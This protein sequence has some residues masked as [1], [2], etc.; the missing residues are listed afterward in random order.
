MSS[1]EKTIEALLEVLAEP[2]IAYQKV[3]SL[4]TGSV[5]AGLLF[6]Q[7][8]YWWRREWPG[9]PK[10]TPFYKTDKDFVEFL[11]MGSR[12]FRNA[13]LKLKKLGIITAKRRGV[14]GRTYYAVEE[15]AFLREIS[16]WAERAK[17]YRP[18]QPNK[19]GRKGQTNTKIT[20]R[21][22]KEIKNHSSTDL[23]SKETKQQNGLILLVRRGVDEKVA[24][25]IVYNQNTPL[26]SIEE[27][28]K[29]GLAKEIEAKRT[30]GRF[31]IE[32]GYIVAALNGARKEGKIVGPT[33][34]S[35]EFSK[36]L[37]RKEQIRNQKPLSQQEF[38]HK[39]KQDLKKLL[40]VG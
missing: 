24:Q 37:E 16:S 18:K 27:V 39:K 5:T 30:G 22:H 21:L 7:I 15:T 2:V 28:I 1:Q 14:P 9:H 36:Q 20:Q 11:A 6:A 25:S 32:A 8:Y 13:K 34:K 23:S 17:L 12:E 31:R 26:E 3:Y 4:I 40:A 33:K 19:T 38:E 29:N 10:K 35:R